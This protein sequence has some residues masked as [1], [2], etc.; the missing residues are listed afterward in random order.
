MQ[1]L[2]EDQ[3][4]VVVKNFREL[5]GKQGDYT[6]Q[7][8]ALEKEV[9]TNAD[10]PGTRFLL[11]FH[12]GYLG[13]PDHAVKQLDKTLKLAPGDQTAKKLRE[14]MGGP[15]QDDQKPGDDK[16]GGD[17]SA[18]DGKTPDKPAAAKDA[19]DT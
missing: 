9:K 7:L 19:V 11:G 18:K 14:A 6:T 17:K 4:G 16:D 15:K 13:Y 1:L 3:W 2:P 10:N 8:R 12:Y 5:Y